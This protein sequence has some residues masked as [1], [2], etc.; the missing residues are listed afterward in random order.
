M[1]RFPIICKLIRIAVTLPVTS[2]EPE[3]CFS[4]M[5]I[6]KSRVR[7]TMVDERLNGLALMYIHP[8]V[9][10]DPEMVVNDFAVSKRKLEFVL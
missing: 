6:L 1:E 4:A 2:C 10:V 5:K 3:R 8:E 7:S 9:N